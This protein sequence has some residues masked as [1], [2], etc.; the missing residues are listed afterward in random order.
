[1]GIMQ[2]FIVMGMMRFNVCHV[3][4]VGP[5]NHHVSINIMHRHIS[6]MFCFIDGLRHS[7]YR[8]C[9]MDVYMNDFSSWK[10]M[11]RHTLTLCGPCLIAILV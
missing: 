7:V 10:C 4:S 8:P 3:S 2:D 9:I 5:Q 11:W 1:M 6:N